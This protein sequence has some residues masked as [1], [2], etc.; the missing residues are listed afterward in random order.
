MNKSDSTTDPMITAQKYI[1]AVNTA[2]PDDFKISESLK[3]GTM[4]K[5]ARTDSDEEQQ[6]KRPFIDPDFPDGTT[7]PNGFLDYTKNVLGIFGIKFRGSLCN[8]LDRCNKT[9]LWGFV[10]GF[11]IFCGDHKWPE[12]IDCKHKICEHPNCQKRANYGSEDESKRFCTG[13]K[14]S[15]MQNTNKKCQECHKEA[16]FALP[17][18]KA[19]H[20]KDHKTDDMV[21][22][23]SKTCLYQGCSIKPSFNVKGSKTGLYCF[24]HKTE[25]MVNVISK[26]CK[27]TDCNTQASFGN[28]DSTAE[29]C[30]KHALPGMIDVVNKICIEQDCTTRAC[31]GIP[32]TTRTHCETHK[33]DSMILLRRITCIESGCNN[34]AINGTPG[35]HATHCSIHKLATQINLIE[36]KCS[37]CGLLEVLIAE[38]RCS[39]CS[40]E[41][42]AKQQTNRLQKQN[43]IGAVIAENNIPYISD[44]QIAVDGDVGCTTKERPDFVI[45][46][47][48]GVHWVSIEV[49]E[50]QHMQGDYTCE[51]VRMQNITQALRQKG[52]FIRYNPDLFKV[53]GK[54]KKADF[55]KRIAVLLKTLDIAMKKTDCETLEVVYLF[56]DEFDENNIKFETLIYTSGHP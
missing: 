31:Y 44:R 28:E 5:R 56:Y 36:H 30:K 15:G 2:E 27:H 4:T 20:C 38:N 47:L 51:N 24:E 39:N 26:R 54:I 52:I 14:L 12:M 34:P 55:N 29:Y 50:H 8:H 13:H 9:S 40:T 18:K 17:D 22:V 49:D 37:N 46:P 48:D 25:S 7:D 10:L 6:S 32:G 33:T 41:M 45:Q 16:I 53:N 43:L 11:P 21:D 42:I 1:D 23:R 19:T 35:N 3:T